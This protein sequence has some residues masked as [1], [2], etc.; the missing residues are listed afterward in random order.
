M[1]SPRSL[2]LDRHQKAEAQLDQIRVRTLAA[3]PLQAP[4][5][6]PIPAPISIWRMLWVEIFHK[7]RAAWAGIGACGLLALGLN[8][9]AVVSADT[10]IPGAAR[11]PLAVREAVRER[12]Q[13]LA[14]LRG[15]DS[16]NSTQPTPV[17]EP[18]RSRRRSALP[19][20]FDL[21]IA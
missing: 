3:I 18:E 14:E 1:K 19:P 13:L 7:P 10:P 21:W 5:S 4:G 12:A 2:L 6:N 17:A 15:Q 9:L 8:G 16:P 20:E 11:V